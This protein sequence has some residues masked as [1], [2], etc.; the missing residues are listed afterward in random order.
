MIYCVEDDE[1]IR[2]IEVYTLRATGFEAEGFA[3]SATFFTALGERLPELVLLDIMLPGADGSEILRRLRA[4]AR[5]AALPVI[6]ATAKGSEYDRVRELDGGADDYLVKPFGMM[7]MTARVRALLRRAGPPQQQTL[8]A[9]KIELDDAAHTVTAAGAQT[10]LTLKE[11]LLLKTLMSAVG[12]VFTRE[13]LLGSVWGGDFVGETRTLDVHV[14]TLRHKLGECGKQI[15]T[16][17]G[18]G[19][20]IQEDAQ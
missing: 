8:R 19:Y 6:M 17:R 12:R 7:E 3:D 10:Q 13:Q 20:K 4:D 15:I 9:G 14:R 11:F 5:T 18:V 1:N 2:D 16:L